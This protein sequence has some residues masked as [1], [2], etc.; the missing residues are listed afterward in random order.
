MDLQTI[1]IIYNR[2]DRA[3]EEAALPKCR[4]LNLGVLVR[5]PLASGY[6]SG[7]YTPDSKFDADD[8]REKW[9]D[10]QRR[11]EQITE[12]QQIKQEEVPNDVPMARWALAWVLQ[13]EA[14][15]CV[16]PGCKSAD[17]VRDNAAAAN[18]DDMVRDDHPQAATTPT[19][20]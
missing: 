18:L 17:Q 2:L 3:S 6:L 11:R 16:I 12:A 4:E 15:T 9:H 7:K 8:V 1:Q 20:V 10:D 13:H 14:V 19:G 5:L